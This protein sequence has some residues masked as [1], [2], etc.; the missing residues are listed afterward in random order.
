[1]TTARGQ[2]DVV[3]LNLIKT[4]NAV[5]N[6]ADLLVHSLYCGVHFAEY[7]PI[8]TIRKVT[9]RDCNMTLSGKKIRSKPR[10]SLKCSGK[11]QTNWHFVSKIENFKHSK[12][13]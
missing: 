13:S 1:M 10:I 11:V 2:S 7:V 12:F 3:G 9:K 6:S 8:N 5:T 4:W